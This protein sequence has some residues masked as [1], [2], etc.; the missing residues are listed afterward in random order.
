MK[1]SQPKQITISEL[2]G[3][4]LF[5]PKINGIRATWDGSNLVTRNNRVIA[6]VPHIVEEIKKAG[7]SHYPFDGE[8]YTDKVSFQVLNGLIRRKKTSDA[9]DSIKFYAF[10]LAESHVLQEKRLV[11]LLEATKGLKHTQFVK[12]I[13]G[14]KAEDHYNK[15]LSDGYEGLIARGNNS[16]YGDG[17]YKI[18]PVFDAEFLCINANAKGII[19]QTSKGEKFKINKYDSGIKTG[20]MVTVE[21]S[22]LTDAG[23]PFQGRI[24]AARYDLPEETKE[25]KKETTQEKKLDDDWMESFFDALVFILKPVVAVVTMFVVFVFTLFSLL[26]G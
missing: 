17:L 16:L 4:L 13:K 23:V 1:L 25:E 8:L 20:E 15:F 10:D 22:M 11:D 6:C 3:S 14:G 21:Y 26:L 7:L 2:K 12:T 9:H 24:K 5:Q 18:K 19:C